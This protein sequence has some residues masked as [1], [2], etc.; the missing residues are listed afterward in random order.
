MLGI[1]NAEIVGPAVGGR[2]CN[3]LCV[4]AQEKYNTKW[5]TVLWEGRPSLMLCWIKE[6]LIFWVIRIF[7]N[8]VY[9]RLILFNLSMKIFRVLIH[10]LANCNK[11]CPLLWRLLEFSLMKENKIIFEPK[12]AIQIPHVSD[13]LRVV[14]IFVSRPHLIIGL[15]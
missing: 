14:G 12:F 9:A 7:T 3:V 5:K 15:S 10:M 6:G 4:E 11:Y 8:L 13:F 2:L 1:W